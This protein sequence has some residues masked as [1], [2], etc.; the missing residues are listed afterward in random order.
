M[1][2]TYQKLDTDQFLFSIDSDDD[3]EAF[4]FYV[5]VWNSVT[6]VL[7]FSGWGSD[8][9]PFEYAD[10]FAECGTYTSLQEVLDSHNDGSQFTC[11]I[12]YEQAVEILAKPSLDF[13]QTLFPELFI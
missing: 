4:V 1:F 7:S 9:R 10:K 12:T 8:S 11:L 6:E 2:S 3:D 13:I 5:A